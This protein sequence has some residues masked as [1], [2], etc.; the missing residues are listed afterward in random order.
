MPISFYRPA[1]YT[2]ATL[3]IHST[4]ITCTYLDIVDNK[5]LEAIRE[6]VSRLLVSA[7]TN[8]GHQILTFE[9][10]PHSVVN[11][12]GLSPVTLQKI[13]SRPTPLQRSFTYLHFL[14]PI[15]LMSNKFF[16]PFMDPPHRSNSCGHT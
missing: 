13:Q 4:A 1:V 14:V 9:P 11:T 6:G 15:R 8:T 12:L 2:P 16:G 3:L 10:S 7:I 5:L